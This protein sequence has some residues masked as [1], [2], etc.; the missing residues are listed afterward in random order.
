MILRACG[1]K[2]ESA[3]TFRAR[4][5]VLA[6]GRRL[7]GP[8]LF[9]WQQHCRKQSNSGTERYPRGSSAAVHPEERHAGANFQQHDTSLAAQEFV[10]R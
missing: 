9:E 6:V 8:K 1:R 5:H 2:N 10:E 3:C 4:T 7:R